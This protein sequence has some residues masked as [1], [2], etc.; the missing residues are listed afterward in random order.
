MTKC[1][2]VKADH[3]KAPGI[4]IAER[5]RALQSAPPRLGGGWIAMANACSA[6]EATAAW[7]AAGRPEGELGRLKRDNM[8]AH[9]NESFDRILGHAEVSE[10]H[11][12]LIAP[13]GVWGATALQA[14][15]QH[16]VFDRRAA[17]K[18][19]PIQ[20]RSVEA[21]AHRPANERDPPGKLRR[22][23]C[24]ASTICDGMRSGSSAKTQPKLLT[25]LS[26][27]RSQ[28]PAS[29]ENS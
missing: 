10:D 9:E 2:L 5:L 14:H 21:R 19:V 1:D 6:K 26:R 23:H 15:L 13:S 7:E 24:A 20:Q 28:F 4:I 11:R 22:N 8:L 25:N 17:A 18:A 3:G 27:A 16:R 12:A 29:G